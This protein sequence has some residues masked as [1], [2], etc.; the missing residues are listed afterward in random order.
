MMIP[1]LPYKNNKL[2]FSNGIMIG[3]Y[4]YEE[5]ILFVENGGIIKKIINSYVYEKSE[6][7]FKDF[8]EYFNEYR[9]KGGFY[10]T[11]GKLIV[12]S[13]YGGFALRED[14][15]FTH[16]TFSDLEAESIRFNFNVISQE[17]IGCIYISKILKDSKSNLIFNKKEMRWSNKFSIRNITYSC[18][19]SSKARIKLYKSFKEVE[20]DGGR[21]LYCDTDSIFASYDTNKKNVS[22]GEIKWS[23][24]YNDGFFI[25]PKFYGYVNENNEKIVKIKGVK[26]KDSIV[27]D[28]IKSK[29]YNNDSLITITDQFVMKFKNLHVY[30]GII[31]K[32][33]KL[34]SYDKR[35]FYENKIMTQAIRYENPY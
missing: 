15:Y 13:L 14:D 3:T 18:I 23:E 29:F 19:I 31:N 28:E 17:Y 34:D 9:K 7:I 1:V 33:I 8:I 25:S 2:F 4:W 27:Y 30:P 16:F 6:Y 11:F 5:I 35:S 22:I 32:S 21:I 26:L 10:K 24:I 12:N 20:R